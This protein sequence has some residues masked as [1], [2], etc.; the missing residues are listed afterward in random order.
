MDVG[1]WSVF[2]QIWY[3][4]VECLDGSVS[5]H[6][7]RRQGFSFYFLLLQSAHKRLI[8]AFFQFDRESINPDYFQTLLTQFSIQS[9][10]QEQGRGAFDKDLKN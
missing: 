1:L 7:N 8:K 2:V 4:L 3:D 10:Q 5:V 9:V 6:Y